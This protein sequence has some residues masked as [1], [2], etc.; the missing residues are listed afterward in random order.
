MNAFS[1]WGIRKGTNYKVLR[2]KT[3]AA[4]VILLVFCDQRLNR[5]NP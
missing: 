2:D 5:M 3:T 1:C 4:V